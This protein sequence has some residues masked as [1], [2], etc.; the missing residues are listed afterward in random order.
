MSRIG[1]SPI[2]MPD[3]VSAQVEGNLI[4][5][6]GPLGTLT[7]EFSD[8]DIKID[9]NVISLTRKNDNNDVKAKHGLYRAL[10]ANMVKGVKEGF[11]RNLIIK[12]VGYKANKVG[13]KL[14]LNLGYS[15]LIE[16]VEPEGIKIECPT[17]TDIKI[18]GIDKQ[19]VGQLASNIRDL[20]KV[21]PYHGYG[22]RYDDEV[23]IRKQGKTAG[24]GKK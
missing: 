15:H 5:V 22:V 24:K 20:R 2:K 1:R 4:T 9:G 6:K 14:V 19:K 13:N 23:V 12:G 11:T 17:A 21:E 10:V 8:V 18:T 16:V 7:Q 3:G